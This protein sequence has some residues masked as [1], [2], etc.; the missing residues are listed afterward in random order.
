[1]HALPNPSDLPTKHSR[2]LL[3]HHNLHNRPLIPPSCP[4]LIIHRREPHHA[5]RD[6][7]AVIHR[8]RLDGR[9]GR[10][11]REKR[12]DD[13][14]DAGEGVDDG[15]ERGGDVEGSPGEGFVLRVGG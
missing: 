5:T 4:E 10:E 7:D 1:M 2:L 9:D 15:A 14:E 11:E 6:K 13:Q 3:P 8:A 12:D